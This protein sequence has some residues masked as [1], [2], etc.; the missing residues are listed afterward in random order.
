MGIIDPEAIEAV[1]AVSEVNSVEETVEM[2]T[3]SSSESTGPV[4]DE[5]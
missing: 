2:P 5:D 4:E 3:E 1:E